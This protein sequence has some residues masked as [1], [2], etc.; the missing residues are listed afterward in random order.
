[1]ASD[2]DKRH[3]TEGGS[4]GAGTT[5]FGGTRL[6]TDLAAASPVLAVG[7]NPFWLAYC[8]CPVALTRSFRQPQLLFTA[9]KGPMHSGHHVQQQL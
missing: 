4:N 9:C 6:T 8:L 3:P 5:G 1:M 7:G 2:G